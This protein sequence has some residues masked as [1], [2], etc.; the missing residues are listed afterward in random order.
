ML[1]VKP[2][3]A[4]TLKVLG[5]VTYADLQVM[6]LELAKEMGWAPPAEEGEGEGEGEKKK[7]KRGKRGSGRSKRVSAD[8]VNK[9]V[10]HEA[11]ETSKVDKKAVD[12]GAE[13]QNE[14]KEEGGDAAKERKTKGVESDSKTKSSRGNRSRS[15]KKDVEADKGPKAESGERGPSKAGQKEKSSAAPAPKKSMKRKLG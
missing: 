12:K 7:T 14:K 15:A 1:G 13:L 6:V 5:D 2:Q 11:Q 9:D 4:G 3:K 8:T 10:A